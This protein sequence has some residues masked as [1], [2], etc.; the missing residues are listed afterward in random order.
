[1]IIKDQFRKNQI[2]LVFYVTFYIMD[3][4]LKF[5]SQRCEILTSWSGWKLTP[6]HCMLYIITNVMF[7][8]ELKFF[9]FHFYF[10][11][12][13]VFMNWSDN[14]FFSRQPLTR[15]LPSTTDWSN[16]LRQQLVTKTD[17]IKFIKWKKLI[18]ILILLRG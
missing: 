4:A 8:F 11:S 7:S 12:L 18:Q 14:I 17:K 10:L 2:F 3:K 1:M 16:R 5:V 6:S 9:T 13:S 15:S